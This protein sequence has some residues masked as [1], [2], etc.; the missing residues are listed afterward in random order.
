[1]QSGIP[2]KAEDICDLGR[3]CYYDH[4]E[5]IGMYGETGLPVWQFYEEFD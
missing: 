1:M 4:K 3:L 2:R 5:N